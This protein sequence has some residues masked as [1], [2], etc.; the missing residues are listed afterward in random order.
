MKI[1]ISTV[2]IFLLGFLVITPA[3]VNAD[4]DPFEEEESENSIRVVSSLFN[5]VSGGDA[6]LHFEMDSD[7]QISEIQILVNNVDQ[8]S[9]FSLI[10]ETNTLSGVVNGLQLGENQILF[11]S[12][13]HEDDDCDGDKGKDYDGEH[14]C[15]NELPEIEIEILDQITLINHPVEGPIFS[16]THQK[17]LVC[18]LQQNGLGQPTV[19]NTESGFPVFALDSNGNPTDVIGFSQNCSAN[20]LVEYLYKSTSG[21]WKPFTV[22]GVRPTDMSQTTTIDDLT[23]DYIVRWERGTINRFIYSIAMLAPY[24]KTI[25][26]LNRDGWNGKLIYYFQGG[27]AIGHEQ[28]SASRRRMLYDDGLSLGYAVAYSTGTKTGTHYNLELGGET[29]LMVKERFVELYDTPVYTVGVGGSGGGIQQY[30]YGQNHKGLIDAAIPQYSYPDMITQVVH[31]GDCELLEFFMDVTDSANPRWSTWSNRSLLEGMNASDVIFNPYTQSAGSSECV[32]GWRGLSPLVFNPHYGFAPGQQLIVPQTD[33]A[34]IEWT[35]AGDLVNIYGTD[36]NGFANRL[37]DN[38]GVQY[39]LSSVAEG[40]ITPQEF[41]NLNA[42][43]GG[44]KPGEEMVQEGSPFFPP[45]EIDFNDLDLWSVRNQQI[46]SDFGVTPAVRSEGSL[47][48]MQAAYKSG[49]VFRGDMQIPTID[50]RH[51]LEDFLDM[52]NSHQSFAARQRIRDYQGHSDNQLIWFT[53]ANPAGLFDQ[54]PEAF[55]VIDEWMTQIR[56]NPERGVA[57]NKPKNATDRCFDSSG[58]EIAAGDNVWNGILN[59]HQQMG[60]C[61]AQFP[62]YT[63]SRIVAGGSFK[64]SIFKCALKKVTQAIDDG[65]YGQ[66]KPSPEQRLRLMQIFPEGVCDYEQ[67]DLGMPGDL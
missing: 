37:W 15:D 34:A 53:A 14:E 23:V 38:V 31:V 11:Q 52:H 44:W 57:G 32:N 58:K 21:E 66:W 28:G 36:Y 45:G 60:K 46:S 65:D 49:L 6:R 42:N 64:G 63:T 29:A 39:G 54:T 19:D 55:A 30:V 67:P 56:E 22:G 16:G 33:V 13:E 9:N 40:K 43:I 26:D 62:V 10:P 41:L 59:S 17:P 7:L 47:D 8:S 4:S 12:V 35:H 18:S 50:W 5:H 51:Y 25:N 61:A 20:T 3:P 48:A 2:V 1:Q 24:D 27:V